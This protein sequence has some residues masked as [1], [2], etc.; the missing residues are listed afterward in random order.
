MLLEDKK[1]SALLRCVQKLGTC[2]PEASEC[3]V[4]YGILCLRSRERMSLSPRLT[5]RAVRATWRPSAHELV[6]TVVAIFRH[7]AAT[8]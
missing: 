6:T 8:W 1:T 4:I 3:C 2:G 7:R 5:R